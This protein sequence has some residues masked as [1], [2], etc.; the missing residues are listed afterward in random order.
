MFL[1]QVLWSVAVYMKHLDQVN[2]LLKHRTCALKWHRRSGWRCVPLRG[3]IHKACWENGISTDCFHFLEAF[4]KSF[5][6]AA[7]NCLKSELL[8]EFSAGEACG[9][10]IH[11][12]PSATGRREAG[13]RAEKHAIFSVVRSQ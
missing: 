5:K 8:C 7:V 12:R 6:H 13:C 9:A 4:L 11:L 3:N 1:V 2:T 10:A